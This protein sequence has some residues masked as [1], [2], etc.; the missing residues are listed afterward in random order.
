ME[1]NFKLLLLLT[2]TLSPAL[3]GPVSEIDWIKSVLRFQ[4][5]PVT[6]T[7]K[8]AWKSFWDSINGWTRNKRSA[9][10]DEEPAT[11]SNPV[12]GD[13]MN[14][15]TEEEDWPED[16]LDEWNRLNSRSV[17][18]EWRPARGHRIEEGGS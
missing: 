8:S 2:F 15:T 4:E 6:T 17:R 12:R 18:F 5:E 10:E 3:S 9:V 1:V 13:K 7:E 16:E 11:T 14:R